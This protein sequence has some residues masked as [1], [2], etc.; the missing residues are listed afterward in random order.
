M[1]QTSREEDEQSVVQSGIPGVKRRLGPSSV[2]CSAAFQ[3]ET[4]RECS[5]WL[6][7]LHLSDNEQ[8]RGLSLDEATSGFSCR[9]A[10]PHKPPTRPPTQPHFLCLST[11]PEG[12]GSVPDKRV[13]N[14]KSGSY[15]GAQHQLNA[16][17]LGGAAG[18]S[19][20]RE[21]A[22]LDVMRGVYACAC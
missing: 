19:E 9:S 5:F 1:R 4:S 17:S 8:R 6:R 21:R 10:S 7:R 14:S 12:F 13:Q 16:P 20:L 15:R 18:Q 2:Q 22:G 3:G 11:P